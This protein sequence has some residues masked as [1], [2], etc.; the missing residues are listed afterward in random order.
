MR[1]PRRY[2]TAQLP[3]SDKRLGEGLYGSIALHAALVL[4]IIWSGT[5]VGGEL[6]GT[7]GGL[8]PAGGGGGGGAHKI[9]YVELLPYTAPAAPAR[10]EPEEEA[11]ELPVPKPETKPIERPIESLDLPVKAAV[12]KAV[13]IGSGR[14]VGG[15]SGDGPGSGGGQG[16]GVGTGTGS[17]EGPGTGG[18]ASYAYAP[19][20]RAVVYP[21]D[22]PPPAIKGLEIQIRFWVDSRG[23][24]TKVDLQTPVEDKSYRKKL[25]EAMLQWV[26]YPARTLE[27]RRV[28]GELV[29]THR[30]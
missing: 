28:D 27:G 17:H 2:P 8:G 15:L 4:L 25:L 5:R 29:V 9:T 21:V 24:V 16:T 22:A 10:A 14:G 3:R 19:E 23:R 20:P 11:V 30:P 26:F 7:G 18:N 6:I 13:T 12:F 1:R